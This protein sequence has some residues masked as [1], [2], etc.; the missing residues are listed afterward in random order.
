MPRGSA[1]RLNGPAVHENW[2]EVCFDGVTYAYPDSNHSTW[3]NKWG[4][5]NTLLASSPLFR[6]LAVLYNDG[7]SVPAGGS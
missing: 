7:T 1:S 3:I 5:A 2:R 4:L 6:D